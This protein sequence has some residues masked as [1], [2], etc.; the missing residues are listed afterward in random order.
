MLLHAHATIYILLHNDDDFFFFGPHATHASIYMLLTL[1]HADDDFR[2]W[3]QEEADCFFFCYFF[4]QEEASQY[5][6]K[7]FNI[8]MQVCCPSLPPPY[9]DR[10]PPL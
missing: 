2:L 6:Q 10:P 8:R 4:L 1:L 3:V 9:R 7:A 5:F